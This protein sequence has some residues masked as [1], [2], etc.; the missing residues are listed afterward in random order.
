MGEASR[1]E[2]AG[3][4]AFGMTT[5]CSGRG[6]FNKEWLAVSIDRLVVD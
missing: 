2:F 3:C 1:V 4:D 6:N 5:G